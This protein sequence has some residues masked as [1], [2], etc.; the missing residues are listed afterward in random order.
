MVRK[1]VAKVEAVVVARPEMAESARGAVVVRA[2]AM[3]AR[4]ATAAEMVA[5]TAGVVR[6]AEVGRG[7]ES[8]AAEEGKAGMVAGPT[9]V[10]E[11]GNQYQCACR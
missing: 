1:E 5:E 6:G 4:V 7:E 9:A 10:G 8:G 2:A 3:G 11:R